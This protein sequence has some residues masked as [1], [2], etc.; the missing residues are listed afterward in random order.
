MLRPLLLLTLALVLFAFPSPLFADAPTA[1]T[2]A[3]GETLYSIARTY[4]L[5]PQQ[6]ADANGIS[7]NGWVYAGQR[8]TIP[9]NA[10]APTPAMTPSGYYVVRAGDTLYSIA[11]RFGMTPSAFAAANWL[12]ADG[13]IYV[14]WSLKIPVTAPNASG[15]RAAPAQTYIVQPGEFLTQI[16]LRYETTVQAITLANNLPN[17]WLIYPGQ[18]LTIPGAPNGS[19]SPSVPAATATDIRVDKIPLYRQQQTLTCEEASV[20]MATRGAVG[21]ARLVAVMPRSDNPFA[22]IR[23]RTNSPYFGGLGDYGAYAQAI[24]KGLNALGVKSEVLYGQRYDVF[25]KATLDHLRAGHPV[26]WW[27][28]WRDT[29]QNPVTVKTLDGATVKLVPYEHAGV[30]VAANDRGVTYHDPYD[31]TVRF[32]SWA[33]H[34]RVSAYFDNMALVV[35]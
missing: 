12:P 26:I 7:V 23:G 34:R 29:Y 32:A 22:G 18:R 14:G 3:W 30:I 11:T 35:P 19:P 24:Q 31:A 1:H 5:T 20:A 15:T 13:V 16:A 9:V 33:D 27:H 8:L 6:V 17:D 28:S 25:K 4:G 2:V 10:T 21:E